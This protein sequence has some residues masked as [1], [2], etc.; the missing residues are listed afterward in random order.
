MKINLGCGHVYKK[1]YVNIDA[2]DDT[3]ADQ[4]MPAHRLEFEDNSA[5]V[6]ECI[7]VIEH[8]GLVPSIYT[9]SEMFRVLKPG[10]KL[11]IETPDIEAT[12]KRFLKTG[13]KDR[14]LLMNWIYGLD[15]PGMHHKFCFPEELL[16]R[17]L[18]EAGFSDLETKQLHKQTNQ[19]TLSVRC[20]KPVKVT[21]HQPLALARRV[22]VEKGIVHLDRQV[23]SI[24]QEK[25]IQELVKEHDLREFFRASMIRSPQ[26]GLHL[27]KAY[28][29]NGH[30]NH[31]SAL[32]YI[33]L[34]EQ[35]LPLDFPSL[36]LRLLEE[37]PSEVASQREALAMVEALTLK[38]IDKLLDGETT[39]LDELQEPQRTLDR[40]KLKLCPHFS[41]EIVRQIAE[42]VVAKGLKAYASD[43]LDQAVE[44]LHEGFKLNRESLLNAWNLA[45]LKR[46]KG[47]IQESK[48]YYT[49]A[50]DLAA[51]FPGAT[52]REF[53]KR[54]LT[55]QREVEDSKMESI[56]KPISRLF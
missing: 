35:T 32:Q 46:L 5:D 40:E 11:L 6:I 54:I 24:E 14:K 7:Q 3:V 22:L 29:E 23:A 26:I 52:R 53:Q 42:R 1:E 16:E 51:L 50:H 10:G 25:L 47:D 18:K 36:M 12:F 49:L 9:I 41:A 13:E 19:P 2:Y 48:R 31:E 33:T 55:E 28:D 30:I 38:S 39:H 34:F 21:Y 17:T 43:D 44:L 8:L 45:R 20:R 4:M 37:I 27:L 56:S 15:R